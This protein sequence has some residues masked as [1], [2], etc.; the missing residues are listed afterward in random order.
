MVLWNHLVF[1]WIFLTSMWEG[2]KNFVEQRFAFTHLSL[3]V[4]RAFSVTVSLKEKHFA[5]H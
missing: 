5:I 2:L 1:I 3:S 4:R